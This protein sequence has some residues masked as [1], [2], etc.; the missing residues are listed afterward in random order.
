M[1]VSVREKIPLSVQPS[2]NP[3]RVSRHARQCRRVGRH[4]P[5]Q[6]MTMAAFAQF[7]IGDGQIVA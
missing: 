7:V 1:F 4:R 6:G 5:L 2:S 3:R